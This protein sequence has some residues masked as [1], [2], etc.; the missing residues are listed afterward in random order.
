[1]DTEGSYGFRYDFSGRALQTAIPTRDFL[2]PLRDIASSSS[3]IAVEA[4]EQALVTEYAPGAGIGWHR[5]KSTFDKVVALSF[6][7]PCVL[8]LRKRTE[9]GW[10]RSRAL[11]EPRSCYSLSGEVRDEWEHSIEPMKALRYSLTFR[12]FQKDFQRPP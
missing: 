8:R 5:D 6:L 2:Q 11:I 7:Q 9:R 10:Q 4:L 3:G 1:M 12:T